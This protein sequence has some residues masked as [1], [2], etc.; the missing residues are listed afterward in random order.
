[1]ITLKI[2]AAPRK[3]IYSELFPF[4]RWKNQLLDAGIRV[5]IFH[6]AS[7]KKLRGSDRLIIQSKYYAR[8]WQQMSSR[9]QKNEQE[10]IEFLIGVK[11][12]TEKLI[13]SDQSALSGSFDFPIINYVDTFAVKQKLKDISYYSDPSGNKNARIWL[14]AEMTHPQQNFVACPRDQLHKI[15]LG[16]STGYN[17]FRNFRHRLS[18]LSNY[19]GYNLYPLKVYKPSVSRPL[20]TSYRGNAKYEDVAELETQRNSVIKVLERLSSRYRILKGA[21]ISKSDYRKELGDLKVSIS[22]FGYGE[23]C[24]RDFESFIAGALVIKPSMEHLDTFPDVY[25]PNQTYIPILWDCSDLEG[26]F[27]DVI[28]NYS[29][30]LEIAKNGQDRFLNTVNNPECFIKALKG[31]IN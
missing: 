20:D 31:I 25:I 23:V 5:E 28:E 19:I 21:K 9:T 12:D 6:D 8:G 1:M 14:N 2:L 17:D 4:F 11:S 16:W 24:Y 26:K 30:Y 7:D 22:P 13:W 3:S 29:S 27:A 15:K 18:F 10:L